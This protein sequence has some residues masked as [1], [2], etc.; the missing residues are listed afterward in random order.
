MVEMSLGGLIALMGLPSAFTGFCFWLIQRKIMKQQNK[1]DEEER[2]R[3]EE[4]EER[5]RLREAQELLLVQGVSAAIALG[6][7]TAKAVQRIPDAHCNG[8]M[9]KALEYAQKV[10]HEQKTF[11]AKQGV[12]F[13]YE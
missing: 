3:R 12:H 13:L 5:Q 1:K 4:E 9:R 7:A 8:D 11:L 6:E 10:K 2:N